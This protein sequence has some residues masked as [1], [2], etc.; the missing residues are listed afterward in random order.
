MEAGGNADPGPDRDVVLDTTARDR[1]ADRPD[2]R[3]KQF[4]NLGF[5]ES[6]VV[7]GHDIFLDN[8]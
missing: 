4:E 8:H 6:G 5:I 7:P 3:K 1:I 2:R